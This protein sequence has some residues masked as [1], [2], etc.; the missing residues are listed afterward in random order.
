MK[1]DTPALLGG[2]TNIY[3]FF[4]WKFQGKQ[5]A[6]TSQQLHFSEQVDIF[7]VWSMT[8]QP[9][10]GHRPKAVGKKKKLRS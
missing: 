6:H 2:W 5:A 10:T 9:E 4:L 1:S 3:I 8:R 7:T